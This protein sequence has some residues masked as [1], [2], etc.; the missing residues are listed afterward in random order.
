MTDQTI[1]CPHCG[2]IIALTEALTHGIEQSVAERMKAE[3]ARQQAE[4]V[5]RA[6]S[7]AHEESQEKL[8]EAQE[9]IAEG[10]KLLGERE[11]KI[12][13]LQASE[14]ELHQAQR[15]L[16]ERREALE[17]EVEQKAK[18]EVQKRSAEIAQRAAAKE[19]EGLESRLNELQV[20]VSE[21]DQKIKKLRDAEMELLKQKR[22]LEEQRADL[23]I[24]AKRQ[25]EQEREQIRS[26]AER[27]AA[28]EHK[29]K[30]A[31]HEK[32]IQD[33]LA[34]MEEMRRKAEQ[35]S[36]QT[37][38]E[39]QEIEL[40]SMLRAAFAQDR[41]EPVPKGVRGADAIQRVA[42]ARGACCG[43]IV[44]E[45]KRTKSWSNGWIAK[46]KEDQRAVGGEFAVIVSA[47][48][49]PEVRQFEF[50]EGVF[51]AGF[52]AALPL[53]SVLRMTLQQLAMAKIAQEGKAQKMEILYAYLSGMEFHNRI[54]AI[55]ETFSSMKKDLDDERKAILKQWAK[56]ER[57][58]GLMM[59]NTTQLWGSLEGIMGGSLPAIESLEIGRLGESAPD[60]GA[61]TAAPPADQGQ[62]F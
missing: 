61:P 35:G 26:A 32:R 40:E 23:E 46:L 29:L 31:E 30:H 11:K 17:R 49:P 27:R 53:A 21:R 16:E 56:R 10:E 42:D 41:V 1:L 2:K 4:A 60:A 55:V 45:S 12:K 51:I 54:A 22:D 39:V 52:E 15:D 20:E 48:L 36:Q 3:F 13:A 28:E 57:Q 14:K 25:V 43:S 9:R 44:W 37:Q 19:R 33:L 62:M 5:A 6:K 8:R 50:R 34:Q 7:K 47:A 59:E 38:G 24:Q 18:A 58:I